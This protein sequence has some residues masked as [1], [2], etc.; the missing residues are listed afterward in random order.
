MSSLAVALTAL[1]NACAA[2]ANAELAWEVAEENLKTCANTPNA[3]FFAE[4]ALFQANEELENIEMCI[5]LLELDIK[6]M[7][8]ELFNDFIRKLIA[9]NQIVEYETRIVRKEKQTIAVRGMHNMLRKKI[10]D[11]FFEATSNVDYSFLYRQVDLL[12]KRLKSLD[13]HSVD[14]FTVLPYWLDDDIQPVLE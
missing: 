12:W 1:D 13:G 8:Q 9:N 10:Y 7:L 14:G 3:I 11:F 5:E 4:N 2:L 6:S